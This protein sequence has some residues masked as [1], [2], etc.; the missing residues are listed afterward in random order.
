MKPSIKIATISALTLLLSANLPSYAQ[1]RHGGWAQ[2]H[3]RRAQVNRRDEHL[4]DMIQKDKGNLGGHYKKLEKED[5]T[6]R[7]QQKL[8]AQMNGGHITKNEQHSLNREEKQLKE[9]VNGD[10]VAQPQ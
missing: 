10:R 4:N 6:I 1:G 7:K 2:S 9:Q 3:P 5:R 8:D